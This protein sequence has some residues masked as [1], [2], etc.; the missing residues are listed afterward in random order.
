MNAP[1]HIAFATVAVL[2]TSMLLNR[3]C[4]LLGLAVAALGS[5]LPDIDTAKSV[6]G[7]VVF[8]LSSP[9]EKRL[10]HRTLAHSLLGIV[11]FALLASPLYVLHQEAAVLVV[12][13]YISHIALDTTSKRGCDLFWPSRLRAVL[14][15]NADWRFTVGG[16]GEMVLLF[17][18]VVACIP[19][20]P[21]ARLGLEGVIDRLSG[22]FDRALREFAAAEGAREYWIVGSM[23]D[24]LTEQPQ[25]GRYRVIGKDGTHL[26]LLQGEGILTLGKADAAHRYPLQVH[27]EKGQPYHT[28][29]TPVALDGKPLGTLHSALKAGNEHWLFGEVTLAEAVYIEEPV[30]RYPPLHATSKTLT[31][32]YA[33]WADLLPYAH[34]EVLHGTVLVKHHLPSDNSR[35]STPSL[36][37][38]PTMH[39]IVPITLTLSSLDGLQVRVG[40]TV[41]VGQIL[42]VDPAIDRQIKELEYHIALLRTTPLLP[43]SGEAPPRL[44]SAGDPAAL[45]AQGVIDKQEYLQLTRQQVTKETREQQARLNILSMEH[46]IAE[47]REKRSI[48]AT[49]AG[50]VLRVK[51]V[52]IQQ[53]A[54]TI[55][56]RLQTLPVEPHRQGAQLPEESRTEPAGDTPGPTG[57]GN[58]TIAS[59]EAAQKLAPQIY[60]D[61]QTEFYCGCR[62]SGRAVDLTSCG[63]QP[64]N[65]SARAKRLEW[66]HVVPAAAFGQ[67]FPAWRDGHPQCVDSKGKR[68]KG[69]NCAKKMVPEF[70]AM[71]GDLHNLQPAIGEVNR[72][73]SNY[74]YALIEGEQR[75]FGACDVE[76]HDR[77]AEPRP[78]I[79][80]DIARIYRYMEAA[81]P[82][83]GILPA[84]QHKLVEA[85]AR[86]DSVDAWECERDRRIMAHQGNANPFVAVHCPR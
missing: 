62:Y 56:L 43:E 21:A 48:R 20:Y 22:N 64:K 86:E 14:P 8:W 36:P 15:G 30:G 24:T 7:R 31:L 70:R 3:P 55:E 61:H 38:P 63:Y 82:D 57:V 25:T 79:R 76:I 11:G 59:F 51:I 84:F 52:D 58:T 5:L 53:E 4:S 54:M 47:Q 83:R 60:A 13:G 12:A 34:V 69:R 80:G 77:K 68:F 67:A 66:E 32:H 42:A 9:W 85:W 50:T 49:I 81:Y 1:T 17:F 2:S 41:R 74:S 19:L 28:E 71:E 73:R 10:G 29:V 27:L 44:Q 33:R 35:V 75:E 39:P 37:P 46:K 65:P 72:L 78:A 45:L 16:K 6:V 40:D 23:R 26:L 18:L